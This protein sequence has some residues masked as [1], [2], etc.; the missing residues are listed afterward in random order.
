MIYIYEGVDLSGKSTL[1]KLK[2]TATGIPIIKKRLEIFQHTRKE[3]LLGK[4]IELITQMF[5]E[6]I[7][8]I[9]KY[10]DFIIDRALLSSLVY[11]KFFNRKVQ[12]DYIYKY[13][14]GVE[15]K[16]IEVNLVIA[17]EK[18]LRKRYELRGES[19]F[20]MEELLIIQKLYIDTATALIEKGSKINII[21]NDNEY[22]E[23]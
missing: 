22:S 16:Y 1:S 18:S 14:L 15:A 17:N 4:D 5:F 21:H 2:A 10:Y 12:L 13:F 8:P 11:S 6:S 20:S 19:I 23:E 9:G 3:W 7:F